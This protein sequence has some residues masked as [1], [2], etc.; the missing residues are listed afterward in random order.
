MPACVPA[1]P[2]VVIVR[3][4][5]RKDSS[6]VGTGI[7][8]QRSGASGTS[9]LEGGRRAPEPDIDL[10]EPPPVLHGRPDAVEPGALVGGAGRCERRARKLLGIEAVGALL[11][12]VAADRQG[13][14]QRLGL[15]AVA[16]P[17]EILNSRLL[18]GQAGSQVRT[19][20]DV[21]RCL[22]KDREWQRAARHVCALI[23]SAAGLIRPY[24]A[25]APTRKMLR[26]LL[27]CRK[28]TGPGNRLRRALVME[29]AMLRAVVIA[30]AFVTFG[31]WAGDSWAGTIS[32][33]DR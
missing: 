11:R 10:L 16:E 27:E 5:S 28:R 13:A 26:W 32:L 8:S 3:T 33:K 30:G 14:R 1:S 15:E 7:G 22:L 21:H 17:R 19:D 29:G 23:F 2:A 6:S 31:F 18:C 25:S 4:P 20:V 12:R 9:D 24:E